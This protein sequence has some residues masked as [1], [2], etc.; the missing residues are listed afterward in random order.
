M[1]SVGEANLLRFSNG[2]VR[3]LPGGNGPINEKRMEELSSFID[4]LQNALILNNDEQEVDNRK[5][6]ESLL[7]LLREILTV[8]TDDRRRD[9]AMPLLQEVSSVVR[10]VAVKVLEKRGSRAMRSM[11][12]LSPSMAS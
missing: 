10:M 1:A 2:L 4:T 6:M 8:L 5:R 3:P 7:S 12:N 11:L 9:E